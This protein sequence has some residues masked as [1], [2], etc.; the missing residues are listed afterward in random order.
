VRDAFRNLMASGIA[1]SE[2]RI[3][4]TFTADRAVMLM[5]ALGDAARTIA[6]MPA[7]FTTYPGSD[8]RVFAATA[9]RARASNSLILDRETLSLFGSII[10]PG[11]IWR[12]MQ[13]MG[14]WIEP[15]LVAEWTRLTRNY[16]DNM[17][18]V[19]PL[20]VV[21][22]AL[23]WIEPDRDVQA[24]RKLALASIDRGEPLHC[25]WSGQRLSRTSLDIDHCLPWSAWPCGDLWNL[26][27]ADRK[28]NQRLKR[29]K[30][31]SAGALAAAQPQIETW[32]QDAWERHPTFGD[33]FR[34]EA[35]AALAVQAN[36]TLPDIF[37]ALEWRRLRLRQDAQVTEWAGA[38]EA[39]L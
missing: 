19:I 12:A 18:L 5:Q 6:A 36:A 31:P 17:G 1:A 15:V 29:D 10:V 25:V 24:A 22:G 28:I 3:G 33:R 21:E 9:R 26:F 32:W 14:A 13:R 8:A 11:H 4:A 2:L 34:R 38:R 7:N 39:A 16:A 23:T 20:G 37:E 30:L 27:P 35:N